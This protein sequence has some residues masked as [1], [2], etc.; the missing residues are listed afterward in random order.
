MRG[1]TNLLMSRKR[2]VGGIRKVR[3]EKCWN[4]LHA[5]IQEFIQ[6]V[7]LGKNPSDDDSTRNKLRETLKPSDY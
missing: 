1:V 7:Y 4:R 5:A 2:V 6:N 3:L